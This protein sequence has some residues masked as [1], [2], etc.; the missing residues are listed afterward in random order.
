MIGIQ[1]YID[2]WLYSGDP[3]PEPY[4]RGAALLTS[5]ML[6]APDERAPRDLFPL[7]PPPGSEAPEP[8][9]LGAEV[10][11]APAQPLELPARSIERGPEPP[12]SS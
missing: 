9:D 12:R 3:N 6:V 4:L 10:P 8:P 5:A 7:A 2:L 11:A 1:G